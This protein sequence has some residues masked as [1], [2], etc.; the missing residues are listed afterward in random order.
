MSPLVRSVRGLSAFALVASLSPLVFGCG[1]G[2]EST[3]PPVPVAVQKVSGDGQSAQAHQ[4]LA[5]P[6]VVK[7][8]DAAG[9]G[10]EGIKVFWT[11]TYPGGS[12]LDST[13]TGQSGVA[14]LAM[15]LDTLAG[16]YTVTASA[17]QLSPVTFTITCTPGPAARLV[18]L[19]QPS[20]VGAL[21]AI[22]PAV[23][24]GVRDQWNNPVT[25]GTVS[26]QIWITG[27]TGAAGATL[28]GT[29]IKS[30]AAGVVSFADLSIDK[31]GTAYTLTALG[32]GMASAWSTPFTVTPTVTTGKAARLVF[33]PLRPSDGTA[34]TPLPPIAVEIVDS[35][36]NQVT[37]AQDSV[38]VRITAGAAPAG[39]T[40]SGANVQRASSGIA[41][42]GSLSLDKAGDYGLTAKAPGLDSAASGGFHVG[43]AA[44]AALAFVDQPTAVTA[45][46]TIVPTVRVTVFDRFGNLTDSA[47]NV[48]MGIA[49]GAGTPGATLAG[50]L[51]RPAA[52]GFAY[53]TDLSLDKAGAGYRLAA[54]GSGLTG[55]TSDTFSV[56]PAPPRLAFVSQP[57]GAALNASLAPAVQVAVR[58]HGGSI[59]D[60]TLSISVSVVGGTPGAVLGGTTVATAVSGIAT[61]SGLEIDKIGV[62]YRLVASA[63]GAVPDTTAVFVI[64]GSA[65]AIAAGVHHTCGIAAGGDAYCFGINNAGQLGNGGG[66]D[67]TFAVAGGLAFTSLA[68][69][70]QHTCGLV[71]SGQA[72]CWGSNEEGQLGDGSATWHAL[73]GAVSGGHLFSE[74]ASAWSHSCALAGGQAYCW[75][76]G[77]EGQL[78]RGDLNSSGVPV[79]VTGGLSFSQIV[80][81]YGFSCGLA[82]TG[83]AYCWGDNSYGQLGDSST[84]ARLAPVAV[85]G[86]MVFTRLGGGLYH[87]CGVT[88]GGGAFC[89]GKNDGGQLGSGDS[90]NHSVPVAVSTALAF[91]DIVGGEYHT[92][93]LTA[94]GEAYCWG[95][96]GSGQLG[97]GS[98]VSHAVPAAVVGGLSFT[99]LRAGSVHTCGI[100]GQGQVYCWGDNFFG[101]LGS[102]AWP[103]ASAPAR[104]SIF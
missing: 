1:G 77:V 53:F 98:E 26:V 75:G 42:F 17:A 96:N 55:A 81:G 69:G 28:S 67:G 30:T 100:T 16:A 50:T 2:K 13:T 65:I 43:A 57:V 88:V 99:A 9:A 95:A 4:P 20:N 33:I 44:A 94:A 101:Q 102:V 56:K 64:R 93:G 29:N 85:R 59:V 86:G 8:V 46:D 91:T 35:L 19:V 11:T 10:V 78:G 14:Q 76:R 52:D 5:Q 40:L 73:P 82:S 63:S 72:F 49:T 27:G 71:A 74:I 89:W 47:T 32:F 36:G 66:A 15:T 22:S 18:F 97:D 60:T 61:F 21:S 80:V 39:A 51:T 7:V 90:V 84:T 79:P 41:V 24:V 38:T 6:L 37:T 45:W 70:W 12:D 68:P 34:G 54:T 83:Q 23:Q 104:V 87:M 48:S 92:C 31:P 25:T 3:S 58:D 62:G 103:G